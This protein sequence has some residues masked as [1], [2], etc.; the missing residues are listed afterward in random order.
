MSFR[1]SLQC[2]RLRDN[3]DF[4]AFLY[5]RT[6]SQA[7]LSGVLQASRKAS[8][9][10]ERCDEVAHHCRATRRVCERSRLSIEH[11]TTQKSLECHADRLD[12]TIWRCTETRLLTVLLVSFKGVRVLTHRIP[13]SF[14]H[15]IQPAASSPS[16]LD[17]LVPPAPVSLRTVCLS[18]MLKRWLHIGL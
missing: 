15:C 12:E 9:R 6:L 8:K 18:E 14:T 1:A 5:A 13:A 16:L 3:R 17:P 7:K 10:K 11:T 4:D 2:T